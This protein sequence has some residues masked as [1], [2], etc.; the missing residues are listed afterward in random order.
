MY[1]DN[2]HYENIMLSTLL[3]PTHTRVPEHQ[4]DENRLPS[5]KTLG[6]RAQVCMCCVCALMRLLWKYGKC[7]FY[8]PTVIQDN[9]L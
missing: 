8:I 7:V 3:S 4:L 1:D 5:Q 6:Q 9:G 2:S